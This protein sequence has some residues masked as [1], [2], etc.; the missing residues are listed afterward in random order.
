MFKLST[1]I[2]NQLDEVL[3]IGDEQIKLWRKQLTEKYL[4]TNSK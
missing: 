2:V 1:Q 4:F 3:R